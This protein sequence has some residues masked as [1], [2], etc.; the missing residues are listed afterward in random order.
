VTGVDAG[1][2]VGAGKKRWPVEDV[3]GVEGR[4]WVY[5]YSRLLDEGRTRSL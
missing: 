1:T 4:D 5:D 3:V 2:L